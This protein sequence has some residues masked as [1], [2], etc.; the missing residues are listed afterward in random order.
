VLDRTGSCEKWDVAVSTTPDRAWLDCAFGGVGDQRD[1]YRQILRRIRRPCAFGWVRGKGLVQGCGM[2]AIADGWAA[3]FCMHTNPWYRRQGIATAIVRRLAQWAEHHEARHMVL[4]VMEPN[5]PAK[6]LYQRCG[7][8]FCY[9]YHY[10]V[11]LA[12]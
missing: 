6:A 8:S 10:R 9:P 2:S 5:A 1:I 4:Q 3:L 12:R 11:G 7:F